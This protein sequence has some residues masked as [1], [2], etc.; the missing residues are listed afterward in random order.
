MEEFQLAPFSK[1]ET[2]EFLE[3]RRSNLS[4]VEIA[5]ATAR[6][7]GNARV[8]EYL[9][10]SWEENVVQNINNS[11]IKVEALI[12]QKCLNIF[13]G[14][15]VFGWNDFE[16][17]EFFTAISLLP[18]PIPL[19]ELANALGWSVNQVNS[20]ASDLAP[21]LEMVSHGVI[22]RDEPTETYIRET[23][24]EESNAQ[25]AIAERL[26]NAQSSSMYAADAL[27]HFLVVI[28]DMD[29]A[30]DLAKSSVYPDSK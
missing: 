20:A 23:Y 12:K 13:R 16:T 2:K 29:R 1:E 9:V 15:H 26:Q 6:S 19:D 27:P 7:R 18:P 4:D 14:L 8:L 5:T 24:S 25:Q 10:E 28:N 11:E 3:T 22:F 30:F 17:I 21:M